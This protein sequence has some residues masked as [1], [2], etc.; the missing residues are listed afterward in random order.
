MSKYIY[1]KSG[2]HRLFLIWF[3]STF[4]QLYKGY[5]GTVVNRALPYLHEGSLENTLTVPLI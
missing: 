5:K 3:G 1:G 4:H 2:L